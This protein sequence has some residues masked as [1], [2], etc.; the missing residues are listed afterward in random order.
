M[1]KDAIVISCDY[2]LM[3][4]ANGADILQDVRDFYNWLATPHNLDQYLPDG[5]SAD[6]D[7]ILVTGESAGGWLALQSSLLP[8]SRKKVSAVISH[9]PM[10]DMRDP[11][12]T[13]DYEKHLFTPVAPQLPRSILRD[14]ISNLKGR[15]VVS[16]AVPPDRV[17]LVISSLQQGKFGEIFGEDSSLYPI[18]VLDSVTDLPPTWILHGTGDT[19]IPVEGTYKYEKRL[20]EK[21]PDAKL[22]VTYRPGD[23]GFDNDPSVSLQTDWVKEGVEF[24]DSFWPRK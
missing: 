11:H 22:H 16:S 21:L 23:H 15:E 10:I 8:A 4:E 1:A 20:R 14:Y 2:R 7:N 9:Y 24:I 6:V 12:Y 13:G 3:P 5:V 19:V 17:P 18:E